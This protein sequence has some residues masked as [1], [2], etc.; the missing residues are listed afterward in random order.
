[1]ADI[2]EK[3]LNG[4]GLAELWTLVKSA[5]EVVLEQVSQR[6]A[7]IQTG[8]YVG[9]GTGREAGASSLTFDFVPKLV[10]IRSTSGSTNS[11]YDRGSAFF[12]AAGLTEEY[13]KCGFVN[14]PDYDASNYAK[15]VGQTLFWY[16]SISASMDAA[17]AEQLN[18]S[19]VTYRWVAFG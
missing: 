9:A 6:F 10:A 5:D 19:G 3:L 2:N 8:S 12:V 18:A 15:V 16:A 1:M 7:K 17:A 13:T 4:A 14:D 11:Q